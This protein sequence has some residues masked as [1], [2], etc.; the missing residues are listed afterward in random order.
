MIIFQKPRKRLL[1]IIKIYETEIP[2]HLVR[3][4]LHALILLLQ[5]LPDQEVD[6]HLHQLLLMVDQELIEV[7]ILNL[8]VNIK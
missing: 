1:S 2:I 6:L 7:L 3:E 5:A 4:A 8:K